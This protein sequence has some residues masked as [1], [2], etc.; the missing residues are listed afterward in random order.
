[1]GLSEGTPKCILPDHLGRA[2]YHGPFVNQAARY[3]DAAAHGG[4]IVTDTQLAERIIAAWR[5][6]A[7][8][9]GEHFLTVSRQQMQPQ[10]QPQQQRHQQQQQQQQQQ[11]APITGRLVKS[12][13]ADIGLLRGPAAAATAAANLHSR[14]SAQLAYV[15]TATPQPTPFLQPVG[16]GPLLVECC[17]LGSFL[18]K[19]NPKPLEMVCFAASALA[20]RSYPATSPGGKGVR[21]VQR[22]GVMDQVSVPLPTT[23]MR[24]GV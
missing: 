17:W 2:D 15:T 22:V 20:G 11:L 24:W 3:A 4:Q 10:P 6:I 8:D 18:Y 23:L 7:K 1:M 21:V 19:G 5:T 9:R 13:S 14:H 12:M 16:T